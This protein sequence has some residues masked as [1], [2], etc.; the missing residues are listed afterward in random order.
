MSLRSR[1][2]RPKVSLEE[3]LIEG[4]L[5]GFL[6]ENTFIFEHQLDQFHSILWTNLEMFGVEAF[7]AFIPMFY[8]TGWRR[9]FGRSC[10]VKLFDAVQK[11][12]FWIIDAG[13]KG[14]KVLYTSIMEVR[15]TASVQDVAVLCIAAAFDATARVRVNIQDVDVRCRDTRVVNEVDCAGKRRNPTA[16]E[17]G[18]SGFWIPLRQSV[19]AVH[20]DYIDCLLSVVVVVRCY[21][22]DM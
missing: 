2:Q 9:L 3:C 12:L 11:G 21:I 8:E 10:P 22:L 20:L 14:K 6:S 15:Q 18:L 1:P 7:W 5:D 16:Y 4:I 13:D 17:P 19:S